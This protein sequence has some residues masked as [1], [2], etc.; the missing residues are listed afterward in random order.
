MKPLLATALS[1]TLASL[2]AGC[3][4]DSKGAW[5]GW[6]DMGFDGNSDDSYC[7]DP[8]APDTCEQIRDDLLDKVDTCALDA[9]VELTEAQLEEAGDALDC[10]NAKAISKEEDSCNSDLDDAECEADGTF[11]LPDSCRGVI[12]SW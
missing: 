1:F 5:C 12:M 11:E 6:L 3:G 7:P 10:E 9:G 8:D 4:A 2:L